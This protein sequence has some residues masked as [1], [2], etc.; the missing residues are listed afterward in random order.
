[1]NIYNSKLWISDLDEVIS[2]FPIISELEGKSVLITGAAGLVCSAVTD[3]LIRYNETHEKKI[4]ILA[5]GRWQEEMI[6]R[7]GDYCE[8]EY[9]VYVPYDASR[10]DNQI[11]ISCDYII[12]G[13]S[14]ASPDMI[15]KEPVE[16]MLSNF[17]GMK[18][19]LDY[20]K[21][22]GTKRVLYIS[23]SEIY[24]KKDNDQS[25]TEQEYGFI[26]LLNSRN[27]YS[28]SKRAAETLCVSYAAEFGVES[29]IVRPGHIY[30]PT[31]SPK[32]NRV[33]SAWAYAAARGNDIVMKSDG[34]QKR[35]YCYCL[36]CATAI[37]LVLLH[38]NRSS[39]YNI[40]N[41]N[42]IISIKTMAEIVAGVG[43]VAL[44]Q[45]IPSEIERH[46]FNPMKNSSLSSSSLQELGWHGLFDA[47][48]G[49]DHTVQILKVIERENNP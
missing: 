29:L 18:Y 42:A 11:S 37:L 30:G 22:C 16:T 21:E 31:A 14:N 45:E 1:M 27:S 44:V 41:P 17:L 19:L 43:G 35:S 36:D 46:S 7:F 4:T 23:S 15:I 39:A 10:T 5:A 48:R 12:H 8:K 34:L 3:V 9:F 38:G 26:D 20:A 47:K 49:F 25:F 6:N 13:A 33:S 2:A 28:V 24:G 40:S 32:D